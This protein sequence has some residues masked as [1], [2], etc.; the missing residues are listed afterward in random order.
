[1]MRAYDEMYLEK[2][3]I[4]LGRMLDFAVYQLGYNINKFFEM[5]IVSGLAKRFENGDVSLLVGKS[6]V[7]MG[8]EVIYK[9]FGEFQPI[10]IEYTV[11]RSPEYW[12]GWVLAYYQWQSGK[13]FSSINK[14]IS[15]EVILEMYYPYH[16]MDIRQTIDAIEQL[17]QSKGND[18]NLK[19]RRKQLG[20]SQSEL[21][22][23]S[24]VPVRTIQQYEQRQKDI[25]VANAERLIK[26]AKILYCRPENLLEKSNNHR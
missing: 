8:Y 25:N 5:F 4:A 7:E 24:G 23:K 16:E 2:A 21:A 6:G 3:R 1:M 22:K 26:L 15:L 10:E 14:E 17:I 9:T 20:F 19:L 12:A 13:S 18:T 11:N